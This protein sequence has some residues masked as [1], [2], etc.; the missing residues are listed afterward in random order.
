MNFFL[1][2]LVLLMVQKYQT[3]NPL[4]MVLKP[5]KLMGFQIP[6]STGFLAG[7]LFAINTRTPV[8]NI[9]CNFQEKKQI[10]GSTTQQ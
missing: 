9:C 10:A 8:T 5:C 6:T 1:V 4:E 2:D 3:N 7:F